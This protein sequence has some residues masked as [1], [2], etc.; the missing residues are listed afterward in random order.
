MPG[1]QELDEELERLAQSPTRY[2][3]N[4]NKHHFLN[5]S[6]TAQPPKKAK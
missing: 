3:Q 6:S 4:Y 5:L 2:T 1:K